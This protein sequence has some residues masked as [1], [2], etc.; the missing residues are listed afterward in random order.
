MTVPLENQD[1]FWPTILKDI[2]A[3]SFHLAHLAESLEF[4]QTLP[5]SSVIVI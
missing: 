2:E 4:N 1:W 3:N 5:S